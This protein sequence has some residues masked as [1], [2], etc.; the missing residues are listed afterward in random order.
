MTVELAA[1]ECLKNQCCGHSST[2]N[3]DR[4]FFILGS[5]KDNNNILDEFNFSQIRLLTIFSVVAT[6]ET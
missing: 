2:F 4:L 6:L 3:F 1:Q 5:N